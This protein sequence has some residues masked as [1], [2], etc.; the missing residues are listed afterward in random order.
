MTAGGGT[1]KGGATASGGSAD[2]GGSPASGGAIAAGGS[3]GLGGSALTTG[4]APGTGG[5]AGTS[6]LGGANAAGGV[7]ATGGARATGGA[8]TAGG[9]AGAGG[10][11]PAAGA[12]ATGGSAAMA[13]ATGMAGGPTTGP[14]PAVSTQHV[15][16][17]VHDPSMIHVGSTFY[18]FATGGRLSVRSSTDL[19]KWSNVG[20]V[21][22]AVP[23]WITTALGTTITE[24]WAP[25]ISYFGGRYHLYYAGSTF[26]SNHSVIG[27]ATNKTLDKSSADYA[28]VDEG[29]IIESNK[30][31]GAK[32]DWN[33]ID[34]S[35]ALDA[36]GQL[37]LVWGSFW[38]G[39]K[40][41]QLDAATGKL[42]TTDT[43]LYSLATASGSHGPEAPSIVYRDP[44]YYLFD[45][46]DACCKGVD[47]TYSTRMGRATSITGPYTD[48]QGGSL[49]QSNAVSLITTSGR[50]IGPGGGTAYRDGNAYYYVYHYYDGSSNGA[51]NLMLREVSFT[52]DGWVTMGPQLW[53]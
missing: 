27:L 20:N 28:W 33:A 15:A 10:A 48:D 3:A 31:G 23:S 17:G 18:L 16:T 53:Q 43:T 13:G 30:T 26:G 40:L 46:W 9:A 1:A 14:Y 51:S 29:L 45:S 11:S 4:G 50:F 34:P 49:L 47:S 2:K 24:L 22:S 35:V 38:S 42:S 36:G 5:T 7:A 6:A 21:F 32:D 8:F 12:S 52:D 44:Y 39:I 25:D 41:R 37:W 19:V